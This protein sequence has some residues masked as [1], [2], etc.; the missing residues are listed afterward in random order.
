MIKQSKLALSSTNTF[1]GVAS[2]M[3]LTMMTSMLLLLDQIDFTKACEI[4][5]FDDK[6]QWLT[7]LGG[8][9]YVTDDLNDMPNNLNPGTSGTTVYDDTSTSWSFDDFTMSS[10]ETA[11][12]VQGND[13]PYTGTFPNGLGNIDGT[14]NISIAGLRHFTHSTNELRD[15]S[16]QF[17]QQIYGFGFDY[18]L[19]VG[20][21]TL[22]ISITD[23]MT[24]TINHSLTLDSTVHFFGVV[25]SEATSA[26]GVHLYHNSV[27]S[28]YLNCK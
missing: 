12:W 18:V 28:V 22:D 25:L 8:A 26:T 1:N 15:L 13:A 17:S 3:L 9:N 6:D 7:A 11:G 20:G 19:K 10:T 5:V 23:D 24:C 21:S 27:V 16:F 14:P 4:T 2:S